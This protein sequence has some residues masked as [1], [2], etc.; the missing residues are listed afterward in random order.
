MLTTQSD[1]ARH[2]AETALLQLATQGNKE[3][4]HTVILYLSS[5]NPYLHSIMLETL[6]ECREALV[7]Q[8]MLHCLGEHCWKSFVPDLRLNDPGAVQRLEESIIQAFSQDVH[9]T[10]NELKSNVLQKGMNDPLPH[11]RQAAAYLLGRRGD[12]STLPILAETINQGELNWQL[13]AI[14]A[15]TQINDPLCGPLLIQILSME[16][17]ELHQEAGRALR[18]LA[19]TIKPALNEALHHSDE[20]IRWHAACVLVETGDVRGVE[21]VTQGLF[22]AHA[23]IRRAS[24]EALANLGERCVPMLL[25][26]LCRPDLSQPTL[27]AFGHTFHSMQSHLVQER[28]RPLLKALQDPTNSSVIPTIAQHLKTEWMQNSP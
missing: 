20:H 12:V 9:P 28:M 10:E 3:A 16:G 18:K 8:N 24:A 5:A 2:T 4:V 21:I 14:E 15:L 7:W 13:R 27:Q 26:A 19:E 22:D 11:I 23:A 17:G 25:Q 6:H 1:T